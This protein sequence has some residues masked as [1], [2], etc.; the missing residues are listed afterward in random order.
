MEHIA[1][2]NLCG[3]KVRL[4]SNI[5]EAVD[6]L[7][8]F[9]YI[10]DMYYGIEQDKEKFDC[11]VFYYHTKN[12]K[13]KILIDCND[14]FFWGDWKFIYRSTAIRTIIV[15]IAERYR[16]QHLTQFTLHAS[17]VSHKNKS[18]VLFGGQGSGKTTTMMKL[19]LENNFCFCSNEHTIIGEVQDKVMLF[20]AN[21]PISI[22]YD[23]LIQSF[24]DLITQFFRKNTTDVW[25]T[26]KRVSPTELGMESSPN[27]SEVKALININ[28][29]KTNSNHF[30]KI[31]DPYKIHAILFEE[32]SRL[33]KGASLP[34]YSSD[35]QIR[36]YC[37]SF[38]SEIANQNRQRIFNLVK[39]K[40]YFLSGSID[41][42]M[43]ILT[44]NFKE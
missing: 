44:S 6:F 36:T 35:G 7:Q 26:K 37:P 29:N 21:G 5:K 28:L 39:N 33:I 18:I 12:I 4:V 13:S 40:L 25:N 31:E 17:S 9:D 11:S 20:G 3:V 27:S 1:I 22:R 15:L 23:S 19:C 14:A 16:Q 24:P 42:C 43:D 8:G 34:I 2:F 38:D 30:F 10:L 41:F 32:S